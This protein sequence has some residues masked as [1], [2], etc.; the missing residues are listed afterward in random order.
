MADQ[1]VLNFEAVLWRPQRKG[2]LLKSLT[3]GQNTGRGLAMSCPR[4]WLSWP[5]VGCLIMQAT[6]DVAMSGDGVSGGSWPS[7]PS[8]VHAFFS[9]T[10]V[11]TVLKF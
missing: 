5:R 9:N 10:G 3:R 7:S 2:K 11:R 1:D 8:A 6:S 4:L